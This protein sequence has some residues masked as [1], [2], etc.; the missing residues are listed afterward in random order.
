[1]PSCSILRPGLLGVGCL[2][3]N[4]LKAWATCETIEEGKQ[5]IRRNRSEQAVKKLAAAREK[6]KA[7]L[8][9]KF[10]DLTFDDVN[11]SIELIES[12]E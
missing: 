5:A 2:P 6:V 10:E 3:C 8:D 1:L 7:C 12:G 4:Q 11:G 9:D